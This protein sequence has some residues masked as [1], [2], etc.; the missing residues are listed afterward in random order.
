MIPSETLPGGP[1]FEHSQD[2]AFVLDAQGE[3]QH[4]TAGL[5]SWLGQPPG[6]FTDAHLRKL[7]V[8]AEPAG[9]SPAPLDCA[10]A[11]QVVSYEAWALVAQEPVLLQI[12][13]LPLPGPAGPRAGVY[14]LV[15]PASTITAATRVLLEREQYL[16][17]IF[18]SIADVTFV[19]DVEAEGRYRFGFVNR[20]FEKT[21]G[22]SVEKVVGRYVQDIIPEPSLSLVLGNYQQ[23]ITTQER[24]VWLEVSDYPTGQVT[25]EVS[26]TP[27]M[28]EAGICRRLVGI[29]H[30]LT[31]QKQVEEKLRLS[32]ERFHYALKATTDAI[33]DWNVAADTLYWGEGFEALFGHQLQQ[34]PAP[35]SHWSDYVHPED[36][37]RVVAGLLEA[38]Y[39]TCDSFWQDEYRFGRADGTWAV[40]FDRG[41]FLRDAQGR[42]VRMIG[43]MRDITAR[44]EAEERQ[45]QMGDKLLAQYTDLQQFTY[46][47]S[48][49]LRA[50]LANALGFVNLLSLVEKSSQ[51]FDDSLQKLGISLQKL[52]LVLSDVNGILSIRDKQ[53]GYRPEPVALAAVCRQALHGLEELLQEC[54]GVLHLAIAEELRVLGSQAYFHSIFHNLVSN[55]IKYRSDARPLRIDIVA[56]TS[57]EQ[58]T[59]ITI[60]DN[61][62][63]FDQEQAGQNLFQLYRRFHPNKPG[64]GI[65]LFL[66]KA[67]VESMRGQITVRSRIDEGT[68]FILCFKPYDPSEN[69]SD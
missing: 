4:V 45:R 30:D 35:F 11:G 62:L 40:V 22:L 33:Y 10:A 26:V 42:P 17:V 53:D 57:P 39:E 67:H 43:A 48:H 51:V 69:L 20:A 56:Q 50:P 58:D 2:A 44:R 37:H 19:L 27:V 24:V 61:G 5:A 47:V 16:S 34:N 49:N 8:P 63:G 59:T 55:A 23:A 25:G 6:Q 3:L 52:D 7:L 36:D 12:T 46:I 18:D 28:D 15:K 32:N 38:A 29:V 64:C 60:S 65:G 14:G 41:Y 13:L 1:R 31:R 66:V 21:T 54:G 68:Q 9:H